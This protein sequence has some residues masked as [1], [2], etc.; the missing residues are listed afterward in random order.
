MPRTAR[1]SVGNLCYHVLNRG[2]ARQQV[3]FKD[4][5]YEAF[6]KAMAHASV[7]VP[8]RVIGWCLM[9]NHFHLVL[10]PH[11]DGDLSDWMQWLCT[12]GPDKG[13]GVSGVVFFLTRPPA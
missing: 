10:R 7:E 8:M 11:Q 2:N 4:G 1:A 13:S 9:P 5:D 12:E 3:F 6:L